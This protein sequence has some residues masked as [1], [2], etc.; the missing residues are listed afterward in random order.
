MTALDAV[1]DPLDRLYDDVDRLLLAENISPRDRAGVERVALHAVGDYQTK[2]GRGVHP[3]LAHPEVTVAEIV[4]DVCDYGVLGWVFR[5]PGVEDITIRGARIRYFQHGRWKAPTLP[6]TERRN[7]HVIMQLIADAGVPLDQEHPVVDR[8]Q[9]L[10]G[11]GRL[12]AAIPPVA[13]VL[14]AT[15]RLYVVR[16]VSMDDLVEWDM[17]SQPAADLLSL[18]LRAKGAVIISGETG[19]GKTTVMSGLLSRVD[20]S[21]RPLLVED[22]RE[23]DFQHDLGGAYQ[24]KP[25]PVDDRPER[26]IAGLLRF[27]LGLRPDLVAVGEVRGREAWDLTGAAGVGAGFVAT[28]HGPDA[29]RALERLARL[30]RG[31]ADRPEPEAIRETFSDLLHFVVHCE[32]G[33]SV[34]GKYLHQV[35]EVRAVVPPIEAIRSF[36]SV[37]IFERPDGLGTPMRWTKLEPPAHV[38]DALERLLPA[39]VDLRDVLSGARP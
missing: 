8:V 19:A 2:A 36:T 29:E 32:R 13:A 27:T 22:Y 23:I 21:M 35:T 12:A 34:E 24:I 3:P 10:D 7:R 1:P 14:D 15:I 31:H 17:L 39:G 16:A 9:I 4:S 18:D 28:V 6:T 26:S 20:V 38:V 11:A 30:S 5:Q 33:M 25:G 37:P